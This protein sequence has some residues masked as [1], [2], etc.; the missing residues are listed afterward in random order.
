MQE[1]KSNY[2]SRS[3]GARWFDHTNGESVLVVGAGGIGSHLSFYLSRLGCHIEL[4]DYDTFEDHNITGQMVGKQH[5]GLNKAIAI[6]KQLLDFS[7][8]SN[9]EVHEKYEK[10][11]ITCPYTFVGPDNMVARTQAFENWIASYNA[12][13][14][15]GYEDK[16]IFIDGR[17]GWDVF[18]IY[19]VKPMNADNY[20]ATLHKDGELPEMECT[21]KQTTYAATM[22]SSMMVN[23]FKNHI[24]NV[25]E[26][27]MTSVPFS[28]AVDLQMMSIE[29]NE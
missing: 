4:Y 1:K 28:T 29:T 15:E 16:A 27:G 9:V 3:K 6:Q 20:R 19:C 21:M 12:G 14:F 5:I 23:Y 8:D 24:I 22:C 10:E 25:N 2:L 17:L 26:F 7:P 11:S 18:E 13:D